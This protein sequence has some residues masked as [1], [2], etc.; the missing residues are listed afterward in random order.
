[1]KNLFKRYRDKFRIWF[2]NYYEARLALPY[3][4]TRF[5][6][7][8]AFIQLTHEEKL[9][10]GSGH[11]LANFWVTTTGM[12]PVL[13]YAV[14]T[15]EWVHVQVI[16]EID[17]GFQLRQET[18]ES[19]AHRLELLKANSVANRQ[20]DLQIVPPPA[21]AEEW[22]LTPITD[23]R[24]EVLKDVFLAFAFYAPLTADMKKRITNG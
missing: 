2:R 18:P 21:Y 17:R 11:H 7:N 12:R 4:I 5:V 13:N 10:L 6:S 8:I 9:D 16:I 23:P 22:N 1:V 15:T 24:L 20:E 3:G 19:A 14:F